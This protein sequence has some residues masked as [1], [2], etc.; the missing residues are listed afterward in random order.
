MT[1]PEVEVALPALRSLLSSAG[2]PY[3]V[4]GGVAVIHH[5]YERT[6]KDLDV[7]IGGGCEASIDPLLSRFGF[8]RLSSAR[9]RHEPTGVQ[10][11]TLVAGRAMVGPRPHV[12]PEPDSLG[13]SAADP[14]IVSLRGLVELKLRAHRQQDIADVVAL[15][16]LRSELEYIELEGA[17]ARELRPELFR[18][19]SDAQ[20]ELSWARENEPE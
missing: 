12:L 17:L 13:S 18:L 16:K 9:L 5:G 2:V 10:V 14:H 8:Q 1:L 4:V 20:E 6:T 11:D 15:L 7:L 3:L 19:W